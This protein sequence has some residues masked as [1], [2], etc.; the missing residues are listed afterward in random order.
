MKRFVKNMLIAVVCFLVVVLLNFI[1][2]RL[3]PGNPIAYL[4]GYAEEDLTASQ[5]SYYR[6]ALHLDEPG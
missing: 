3:L 5:I 2:P 6:A 1:L 4:S